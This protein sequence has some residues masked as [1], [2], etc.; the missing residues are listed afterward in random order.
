MD[1]NIC[2]LPSDEG[3]DNVNFALPGVLQTFDRTEK[4]DRYVQQ[5]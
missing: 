3:T 2:S 1:A 4:K 5:T